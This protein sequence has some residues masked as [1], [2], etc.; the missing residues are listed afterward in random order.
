MSDPRK[1][2]LV[3][4]NFEMRINT[5][6]SKEELEYWSLFCFVFAFTGIIFKYKVCLWT[7]VVCCVAYLANLKSKD[8]GARQIVSSVSLS[9]MGLV[10]AYFG[11]N[12]NLFV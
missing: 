6:D 9:L 7:S 4:S 1:E 3:V 2:S 5:A 12:A 11:P 8:I 10:M